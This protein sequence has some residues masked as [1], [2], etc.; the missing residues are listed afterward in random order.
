[1]AKTLLL[2]I[3]SRN[4]DTYVNVLTHCVKQ[5]KVEDIVFVG[6][7]GLAEEGAELDELVRKIC[8]RVR[9]LAE[10][11]NVYKSVSQSLPSDEKLREKIM[12]IDFLRPHLSLARIKKNYNKSDDVIVDVTATST[13][14]SGNLM[15]SFMTEGF[16]HICYFA[17]HDK[18][19]N[20]SWEKAGKTKLYHDLVGDKAQSYYSYADFSKSDSVRYSFDKLRSRGRWIKLLL[21]FSSLLAISV[22]VLLSIKQVNIA[23]ITAIISAITLLIGLLESL[24]DLSKQFIGLTPA[25]K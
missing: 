11:N 22:A 14:V 6:R 19:Y 12:R 7:E 8:A 16:D 5:E 1:M 23:Q 10:Q 24:T 3:Q 17:L 4:I 15:T 13:Q 25:D 21:I 2:F 20:P 9:N 18:V